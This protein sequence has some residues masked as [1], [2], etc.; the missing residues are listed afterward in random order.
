MSY[1]HAI[2]GPRWPTKGPCTI[3]PTPACM[4]A[5]CQL[6]QRNWGVSE[7]EEKRRERERREGRGEVDG[8]PIYPPYFWFDF[9]HSR[10]KSKKVGDFKHMVPLNEST[11]S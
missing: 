1:T 9:I 7:R 4:L 8:T 5:F 10:E 3:V 6:R 11:P 2:A